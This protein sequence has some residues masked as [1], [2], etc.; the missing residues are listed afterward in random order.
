MIRYVSQ[1]ST[2]REQTL[3][4]EVELQLSKCEVLTKQ[5]YYY[6]RRCGLTREIILM[7]IANEKKRL[8]F[9]TFV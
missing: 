4:K 1:I 8:V 7:Y 9:T 2:E 5:D 3:S 6:K